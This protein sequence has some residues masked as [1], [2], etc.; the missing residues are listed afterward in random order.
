M[1][2]DL[3]EDLTVEVTYIGVDGNWHVWNFKFKNDGD[4]ICSLVKYKTTSPDA[5]TS[6]DILLDDRESVEC[7]W[8]AVTWWYG[9]LWEALKMGG[10]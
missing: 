4:V 10:L 3:D 9:S 8:T 1:I 7:D 6:L 2:I 5:R